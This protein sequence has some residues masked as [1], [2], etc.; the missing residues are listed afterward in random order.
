MHY[1]LLENKSGI[2]SP[3]YAFSTLPNIHAAA[4]TGGIS[5]YPIFERFLAPGRLGEIRCAL[6]PHHDDKLPLRSCALAKKSLTLLA[7]N[8]RNERTAL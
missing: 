3:D 8:G 2:V 7:E 1:A 4:L 5:G 6:A